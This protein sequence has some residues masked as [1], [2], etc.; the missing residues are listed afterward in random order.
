MQPLESRFSDASQLDAPA[1][2]GPSA[3]RALACLLGFGAVSACAGLVGPPV[4]VVSAAELVGPV[5]HLVA[6]GVVSTADGEYSPTF[7]RA[8]GELV[9]MRR[10]PGK[11]DY[12]LYTS[13]LEDGRWTT[14]Q[15]LPFSGEHRDAAPYFSP[16]GGTLLFDSRRP[17]DG[18]EPRSINLWRAERDGD[19]WTEPRLLR[20]A[21]KNAPV[22]DRV[23]ADEF[24][25]AVDAAGR[26]SFYSFR[27]PFRGGARYFV[28]PGAP[29]D[30][31]LD[32]DTPDPSAPTFVGYHYVDPVG[33]VVLLEGRAEG[34][35][36]NDLFWSARGADGAWSPALPL[37]ALNTR[38]AEG[39]PF[40]SSDGQLLFFTSDRRAD[41]SGAGDA[42]LYVVETRDLPFYGALAGA[43]R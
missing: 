30:V 27:P 15:P 9:F 32:A 33:D 23:G 14:P 1:L 5:A 43:S 4:A 22:E 8:R 39:G 36:D 17:A 19:G 6:P 11:F 31:T 35:R 34:R 42:D 18:L 28:G 3:V 24:G 2:R 41:S 26:L 37:A 29:G 12:T 13:R 7:D 40:L 20:A 10:T 38:A 25:P 16:D 21:S